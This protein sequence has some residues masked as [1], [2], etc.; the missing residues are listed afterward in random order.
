MCL[1]FYAKQMPQKNKAVLLNELFLKISTLSTVP[2][3]VRRERKRRDVLTRI[4]V[5]EGPLAALRDCVDH[6][7]RIKVRTHIFY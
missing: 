1:V 3:P 5:A 6:R 2:A 4:E 7:L